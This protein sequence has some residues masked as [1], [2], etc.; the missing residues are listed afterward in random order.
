[1]KR[2]E[3]KIFKIFL[4]LLLL[5][6]IG[7]YFSFNALAV[8]TESFNDGDKSITEKD[9]KVNDQISSDDDFN[10]SGG[11]LI[12]K[13]ISNGT[14]TP[15]NTEFMVIGPNDYNKVIKYSEFI[16]GEYQLENLVLG[17]Y[18]VTESLADVDGYVLD[19]QGNTNVVIDAEHLSQS[20][21][22]TNHYEMTR[23]SI[24]RTNNE[25]VL[26]SG[27]QL[28]IQELD[29][30]VVKCFETDGTEYQLDGV[31]IAGKSYVLHEVKAPEGYRI[32]D[33]ILFTVYLDGNVKHIEMSSLKENSERKANLT[34]YQVDQDENL[35]EGA[36][37]TLVRIIEDG[38]EIIVG[39]VDKG[40]RFDFMD[41]EDGHYVV[42]ESVV[43]KG[44]EGI[45]PFE[46]DVIDGVIHY[47]GAPETLFVIMNVDNGLTPVDVL[48]GN[49]DKE[50]DKKDLIHNPSKKIIYKKVNHNVKQVDTSDDQNIIIYVG[51]GLV[52]GVLAF[53]L[54]K[55]KKEK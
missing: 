13:K 6:S 27:S 16:D 55:K 2:K 51:V 8:E 35:L 25:K 9:S 14:V 19:V 31:L 32:A 20:I 7:S 50:K 47:E 33:D 48:S 5:I 30:R 38:N 10:Q 54:L 37:F 41:L 17:E 53:I 34:I 18:K 12:I 39:T 46:I 40:P 11:T 22:F 3:L 4:S 45:E 43:P 29:G 49:T 21:T 26:L 44:Y 42:Y 15:E 23:V 24:S 1:M 52:A 28:E 36:S